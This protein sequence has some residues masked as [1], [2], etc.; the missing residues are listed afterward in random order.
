MTKKNVIVYLYSSNLK[1]IYFINRQL[2]LELCAI[3]R[4]INEAYGKQLAMGMAA[5]F[6]Y[7]TGYSYCLYLFYNEP[8]ISTTTKILNCSTISCN[9]TVCVLRMIYLIKQ[10]VA[11]TSEVSIQTLNHPTTI[12][13]HTLSAT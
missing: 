3:T 7:V 2:H 11:V 8:S 13:Y 10:S 6:I 4:E 9:L 5:K 12:I 1:C